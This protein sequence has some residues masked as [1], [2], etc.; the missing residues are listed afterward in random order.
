MFRNEIKLGKVYK[1]RKGFVLFPQCVIL[2]R[3]LDGE[4]YYYFDIQAGEMRSY[5][6]DNDMIL[7]FEL[8]EG[9]YE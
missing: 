2:L 5:L 4:R 8:A 9:G 7:A 6:T 1:A 3:K